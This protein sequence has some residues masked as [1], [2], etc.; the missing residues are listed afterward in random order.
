MVSFH[1]VF[2]KWSRVSHYVGIKDHQSAI[3]SFS[4]G[5]VQST[6]LVEMWVLRYQRGRDKSSIEIPGGIP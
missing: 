4:N 2:F 1:R 5:M 3:S 6:P